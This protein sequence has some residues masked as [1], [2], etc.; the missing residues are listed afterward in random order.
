MRIGT[1]DAYW[2]ARWTVCAVCGRLLGS[3]PDNSIIGPCHIDCGWSL[4]D[5]AIGLADP[6]TR[7]SYKIS[8]YG[9]RAYRSERVAYMALEHTNL[10]AISLFADY[11]S[12]HPSL[13]K[14]DVPQ[15][16]RT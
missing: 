11:F 14:Y 3:R 1:D 2:R 8:I 7:N 13:E 9:H 15:I 10:M 4:G 12:Q 16:D 5:V 6:D